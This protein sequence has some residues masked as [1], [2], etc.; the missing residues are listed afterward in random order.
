VSSGTRRLTPSRFV[1][2]PYALVALLATANPAVAQDY[3]GHFSV[4]FS[5][6]PDVSNNTGRQPV[7]E[8]RTSLFVEGLHDVGESLHL[9]AGV[10]AE[11]LLADRDGSGAADTSAAAILRPAD[12]YAEWRAE[13]FDVRAGMSRI[14]WGRLDELQPTDVVN[15]LDLTRFVFEGR[16]EARLPVA[17]VRGRAFLPRDATIE[18]IVAPWFRRGRFDQL[19]EETS[20]FLL[21]PAGRRERHVPGFALRN[22]QGGARFTATAG[23]VDWGVS[24]WSGFESFPVYTLQPFEAEPL[25][26]IFPTWTESFPRFT[27]VGGDFEA[28]RGPWGVRGEAAW[29]TGDTTRTFEG[30]VGADRR[31]GDYRIAANVVVSRADDTDVTLVGWGERS[32]RAETRRVRLLAVYDPDDDT[33]FVR[34]IAAISLRDNLWLDG[35]AGWFGGDSLELLGRLSMRDFLYVRV[36]VHF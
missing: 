17:L 26:L 16:S 2:S 11:A 18:G 13:R 23:R 20:P 27:M 34:G 30:G 12:V 19:D 15:P 9:R 14:T 31:A 21:A 33:A 7:T 3:D 8:L 29:F 35:S 4:L 32:F 6:M 28:V 10:F 5:T 36:R 22:L 24:T 1:P 25:A